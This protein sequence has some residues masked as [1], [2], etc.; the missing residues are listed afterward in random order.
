QALKVLSARMK[1][2]RRAEDFVARI[3]GDEFALIIRR[4]ATA[5]DEMIMSWMERVFQPFEVA[6]QTVTLGAS[7]G[8]SRHRAGESAEALVN[9]ADKLMYEAKRVRGG[10]GIMIRSD[11]EQVMLGAGG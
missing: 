6:G 9:P 1:G 2:V 10:G 3:G 4:G 7:V 5:T 8:V 11:L